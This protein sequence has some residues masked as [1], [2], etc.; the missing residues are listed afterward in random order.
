MCIF[1]VMNFP[2]MDADSTSFADQV[3]KNQFSGEMVVTLLI[4][5]I[6]MIT[7]R[8]I[9]KSKSFVESRDALSNLKV[10]QKKKKQN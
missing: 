5:I 7:D 10:K 2:S 8:Y 4:L 3:S 1:I 9:Y 6:I